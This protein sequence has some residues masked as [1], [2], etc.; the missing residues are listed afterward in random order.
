MK[1]YCDYGNDPMPATKQVNRVGKYLKKHMDG[2]YKYVQRANECD[3]Y[4][5]LLYQLKPEYGG[6]PN[7]VH[8]MTID[9]NITTYQNKLRVNTIEVTPEERTLGF[10]LIK[11]EDLRN[12]EQGKEIVQMIVGNRI[13]K[14]Y[15]DYLILF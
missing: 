11:P 3:V 6:L 12:L 1:I 7:D 4:V 2:A 10:D 15:R 13:R 5:T 8:E 9:I 14:A